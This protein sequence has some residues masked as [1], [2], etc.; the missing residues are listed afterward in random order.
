MYKF[1]E[2]LFVNFVA[3]SRAIHM[4]SQTTNTWLWK[5][6]CCINISN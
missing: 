5:T 2:L 4:W 1:V 3:V 6:S